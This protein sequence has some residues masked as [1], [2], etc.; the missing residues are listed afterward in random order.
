MGFPSPCDITPPAL[1]P[2]LAHAPSIPHSLPPFLLPSP[3]STN[4][5]VPLGI[6]G[7]KDR[8]L[9]GAVDATAQEGGERALYKGRREGGRREGG[10]VGEMSFGRK[11]SIECSTLIPYSKVYHISPDLQ[12]STSMHSLPFYFLSPFSLPLS[13]PQNTLLSHPHLVQA[14]QALRLEHGREGGDHPR[15]L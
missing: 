15:A 7:L 1:S 13:L 12:V 3:A 5:V 14:R 2:S 8:E 9:S 11:A 4:L 10:R 6:E